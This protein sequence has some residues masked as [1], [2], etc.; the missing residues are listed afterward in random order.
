MQ[1]A[2][3]RTKEKKTNSPLRLI[4]CVTK[5]LPERRD[6]DVAWSKEAGTPG[7]GGAEARRRGASAPPAPGDPTGAKAGRFHRSK[8]LERPPAADRVE[9]SH[10]PTAA[11]GSRS[12][13]RGKGNDTLPEQRPGDPFVFFFGGANLLAAVTQCFG[14]R[15]SMPSLVN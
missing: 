6:R 14:H 11:P 12:G 15:D 13:S 10:I 4:Y 3:E 5:I 8:G 1:Y 2:P 9:V 7:A